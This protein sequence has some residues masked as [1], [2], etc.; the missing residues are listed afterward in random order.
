MKILLFILLIPQLAHA[1]KYKI[2]GNDKTRDKVI[3]REIKDLIPNPANEEILKIIDRRLWNLRIFSK[4][5][6]SKDQDTVIIK[7]KERWTFIPIAGYIS[8]GGTTYYALGAYDINT[9]GTNTETGIQYERLN[10]YPAGMIWFRKP[11]FLENRNLLFGVDLESISRIRKLFERD[12][13]TDGAFTLRRKRVNTYLERKWDDD[14]YKVGLQLDYHGDFVSDNDL[15]SEQL[16]ENQENSF[17]PEEDSINLWKTI[18]FA[19]GRLNFEN[20]LMHGKQFRIKFSHISTS[21]DQN[22]DSYEVTARYNYYHLFKNRSNF[23]FQVLISQTDIKLRQYLNYLGGLS[24]VRGYRDGQF[25][26][27]GYIQANIEQR[28]DLTKIKFVQFQGVVFSDLANEASSIG[29]AI[30]NFGE[31]LFSAGFGVRLIVPKIYRF[32]GRLDFAQTFTRF[33]DKSFAIGIQQFF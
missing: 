17:F 25:Y 1:F 13:D 33:Q 14:F 27:Q 22:F 28:F 30:E 20:Y 6:I 4:V 18:Y 29:E 32:V 11:Q 7:V 9:L 12:G 24:E 15:T 10:N 3:I 2:V 21:A 8:G 16:E 26:D 23:A 31:P 5:E 19:A